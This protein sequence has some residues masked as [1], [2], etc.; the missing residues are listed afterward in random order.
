MSQ[1]LN[2]HGTILFTQTKNPISGLFIEAWEQDVKYPD[3]LGRLTIK[4]DGKFK[5][6]FDAGQ[7]K[8]NYK[9]Q[10]LIVFF[11]R[12]IGMAI[13]CIISVMKYIRLQ[14]KEQK[15]LSYQLK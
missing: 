9:D 10:N 11:K 7:R 8:D 12:K 4:K 3:L 6:S 2:I 15:K 14:N 1:T 5:F 13:C